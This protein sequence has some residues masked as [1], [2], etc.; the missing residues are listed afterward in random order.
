MTATTIKV[1]S[2]LR[3]R[4]NAL[5]AQEGRTAGSVIEMLLEQYLRRQ[6]VER[7]KRQMREASPEVWADYLA[8]SRE[9]DV[10]AND[11]L[12]NDPWED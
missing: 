5:A 3:D 11:G 2:D 4:I 10:M 7:A 12:E 6:K 9:W 8:E 1:D